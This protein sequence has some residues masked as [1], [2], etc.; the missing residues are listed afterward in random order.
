MRVIAEDKLLEFWEVHPDSENPLKT[1][2][3]EAKK[4]DWKT[5]VDVKARYISASILGNNRVVFN[6]KGNKYRLVVAVDYEK[7]IVRIR[8]IG[9]HADYDKIDA[10]KI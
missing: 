3:Y 7:G 1:W 9:K 2:Y 4:A 5:P 10:E 8:F 6:I